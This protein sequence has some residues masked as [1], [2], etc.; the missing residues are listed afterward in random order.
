[1]LSGKHEFKI[2]QHYK[3]FSSDSA[4]VGMYWDPLTALILRKE[5]NI[6]L[7]MGSLFMNFYELVI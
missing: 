5:T 2:F 6:D 1:M 3:F 4:A 7:K